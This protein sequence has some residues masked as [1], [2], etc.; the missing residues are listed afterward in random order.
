MK[1]HPLF[2]FR[3]GDWMDGTPYRVVRPIGAGGMG[4]V[5]E[6][7][8][9]RTGTRRAV[10]VTR[11]SE[12]RSTEQRRLLREARTLQTIHHP[13]VVR[14]FEVGAL[15]DGR[16]YFAMEL[17]QGCSLRTFI[18]AQAP[19]SYSQAVHLVLQVLDGLAA[20]H[21]RGFVHRDV[22]PS[23]VFMDRQGVAKVI[24]LGIVKPLSPYASG[25]RTRAG[26]VLGTARYMAP[27][28]M[29]AGPVDRRA[30]VYS[31]GLIL[32]ELI[33]G[34]A[35]TDEAWNDGTQVA[36]PKDLPPKIKYAICCA[37]ARDRNRR[38]RN[39]DDMAD[40]LRSWC[41]EQE[42]MLETATVAIPV[43]SL[44]RLE[45]RVSA[46][47]TT[48]VPMH[49]SVAHRVRA[50]LPSLKL[51]AAAFAIC[52]ASIMAGMAWKKAICAQTDPSHN[53]DAAAASLPSGIMTRTSVAR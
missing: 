20:I 48:V 17:L 30:D 26:V 50:A 22:K 25:P 2:S 4:E 8:H 46:C 1:N 32:L 9:T 38:F 51:G 49:R 10:K 43:P 28:Q 11:R 35:A 18:A 42:M 27:E 5:Y 16:P 44:P 37:L 52:F 41:S 24:D 13:N 15:S 3:P 29:F 7:D 36:L 47:C 34:K 21:A 39:A 31:V 23:N 14:V 40:V 45:P 53:V 12:P 6:V 33:V 19:F